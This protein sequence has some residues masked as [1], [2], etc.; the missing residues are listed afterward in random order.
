MIDRTGASA[1]IPE[2]VSNILLRD[3]SAASAALSLFRQIPMGTKIN[4]LPILAALPAAYWV[5]GD[6][7]LKGVTKAEWGNKYLTAEEI[8][9][10]VPIP[11]ALLDDTSY[12]IWGAVRPLMA[13]AIARKLDA[14]V[15]FSE[16][17][18]ASFPTGII[19]EAIARSHEVARGTNTA[20]E[21]GVAQDISDAFALVEADGFAVSGII[22]NQRYKGLLRGARDANGVLLNEVTPNSAYGV[23]IQ[24]P[25]QG[26][27]PTAA[28]TA[29]LL[30]GDFSHGILGTRQDITYKLHDQATLYDE[31][32]DVLYALAQQDMVA[33]RVVARYGFQ[34]DNT[35]TYANTNEATRYPWAVVSSPAA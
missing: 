10:I 19:P 33:L 13:S 27:W 7:G 25:M 3:I 1:L 34:V 8:A 20:A 2:E 16:D 35:I 30:A 32:G 14:A 12:D 15:F 11:E 24:Y 18:P 29:E 28:E 21:G 4:R 26:L 5:D 31:N 6:T 9:T 22:A 23:N 17:K